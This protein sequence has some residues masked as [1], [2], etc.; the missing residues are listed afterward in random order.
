MTI[1]R[2]MC[3]PPDSP[4]FVGAS[5]ERLR[6]DLTRGIDERALTGVRSGFTIN[7]TS[8]GGGSTGTRDVNSPLVPLFT[9]AVGDWLGG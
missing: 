7:E 1:R 8:M 5:C 4:R 2:K 3:R 6:R 9:P